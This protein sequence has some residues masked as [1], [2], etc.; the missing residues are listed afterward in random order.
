MARF[1]A[2]G[3]SFLLLMLTACDRPPLDPA[4]A[5][6]MPV[7]LD[8]ARYL[9]AQC[10][11]EPIAVNG[12]WLP[13]AD[14]IKGL[15][16]ALA[17]VLLQKLRDAPRLALTP[18]PT[19]YYRQYAGVLVESEPR[20]LFIYINGIHESY[21]QLAP[22]QTKWRWRP[23]VVCGGGIWYFGALYNVGSGKIHWF[24]FNRS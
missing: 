7:D 4:R 5:A 24:E 10:E 18:A 13:N 2:L 6:V 22:D 23:V 11:R 14:H 17:E 15:E 21:V 8:S 1:A 20:K 16:K 19:N 12:A 9:A 3:A